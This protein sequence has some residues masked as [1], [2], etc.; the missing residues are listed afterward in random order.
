MPIYKVQG[1]DGHLYSFNGPD[2]ATDDEKIEFASDLYEKR[3]AEIANSPQNKSWLGDLRTAAA[4]SSQNI[5]GGIAHL[6][7]IPSQITRGTTPFTDLATRAGGITGYEPGKRAK[8][9]EQEHSPGYQEGKREQAEAW[10][11]GSA[12]DVM[13]SY[14]RHPGTTAAAIAGALPTMASGIALGGAFGELA[15][16]ASPAIRG[17]IG[18]GAA[19]TGTTAQEL[20]SAPVDERK[21][22]AAATGAGF[23]TGLIGFGGASLARKLGV[24]DPSTLLIGGKSKLNPS[25]ITDFKKAASRGLAMRMGVGA[26]SEGI[27]QELPQSAQEQM[28]QNWAT[29]KD[30]FEGVPQASVEGVLAGS[31]L[32]VATNIPKNREVQQTLA[33]IKE[34]EAA[35][36]QTELNKAAQEEEARVADEQHADL[37]AG[38]GMAQQEMAS[39]DFDRVQAENAAMVPPAPIAPA[40]P[41]PDTITPEPQVTPAL[42]EPQAT[43]A[44]IEPQVTPAP[45]EPQVPVAPPAPAPAPIT[46]PATQPI[47][48]TDKMITDWGVTKGSKEARTLRD[49]IAAVG[50]VATVEQVEQIKS[51]LDNH[52]QSKHRTPKQIELGTAGLTQLDT[53]QS[54]LQLQGAI[55]EQAEAVTDIEAGGDRGAAIGPRIEP[56]LSLPTQQQI[57]APE[58]VKR[59]ETRG[60]DVY[61]AA[62]VAGDDISGRSKE[63]GPDTL[64]TIPTTEKLIIPDSPRKDKIDRYVDE[65]GGFWN[66]DDQ[67]EGSIDEKPIKPS[68][69]ERA[70]IN[71]KMARR[72]PQLSKKGKGKQPKKIASTIDKIREAVSKLISPRQIASKP[73]VIVDSLHELTGIVPEEILNQVGE[74][75]AFTHGNQ[76]YYVANR[77]PEG[78]EVGTVL[79]EKGG[80]MGLTALIG[81]A[82]VKA[83]AN[84]I[85][86]WATP[87]S[88]LTSTTAKNKPENQIA[89]EAK[90]KA[91][92]SGEKPGSARYDQELIAYFT[93]I[94]VNKY[95]I[96]PFKKQPEKYKVVIGWLQDLWAGVTYTLHKLHYN[97]NALTADDVVQLVLGA[98]QVD[99]TINPKTEAQAKAAPVPPQASFAPKP[100]PTQKDKADAQAEGIKLY[101]APAEKNLIGR[102]KQSVKDRTDNDPWGW[103]R[104]MLASDAPHAYKA[105]TMFG[106][107][108][109]LNPATGKEHGMYA[110][111]RAT[112]SDTF[113]KEAGRH[114]YLEL[115]KEGVPHVRDSKDNLY[116]LGKVA[117]E[118]KAAMKA[119]G[120]SDV[121]ADTSFAYM[122]L[123]DRYHELQANGIIDPSE[124]SQKEYLYGKKM[125]AKY[126][127]GFNAW[128]D[129][130]NAIREKTLKFL[131]DTGTFT[132]EKAKQFLDNM[133]YVPFN[134]EQGAQETN[135]QFMGNILSGKRERH[136]KGS[137]R[138]IKDVMENVIDNQLWL[139]KRG[140]NN[141]TANLIADSMAEM[142]KQN[143]LMGGHEVKSKNRKDKDG[144]IIS[145]MKDGKEQFFKVHNKNDAAIFTAPPIWAGITIDILKAA[146][147]LLRKGITLTPRFQY[148]Q[149]IQDPMRAPI[150]AGTKKGI[151]GL[152]K[153]SIPETIKNLRG[154]TPSAKELRRTG[155]AGQIDIHDTTKNWNRTLRGEKRTGV[156]KWLNKAEEI[157]QT[158]DLGLRSAIYKDAIDSGKS[159]NEASLRALM[160]FNPQKR[161]Q[162]AFVNFLIDTIPFMSS[163][164]Q[165]DYKL[166]MALQG[167]IPGVTK[168]DAKQMVMWRVAK[169]AGFATLYA[170]AMSGDDEYENADEGV[171]N[172]NF[173]F[174]G[175]IRIP[176]PPEL[177]LVK[178]AAEKSYRL[179]TE[180]EN[181]TASKA[182]RAGLSEA[183]GLVI[184]ASDLST[185]LMKPMLEN[186]T[187]HSLFTG[188]P[189][190][191]ESLQGRDV[192]LQ[193][194]E[195]TSSM[196]KAIS[197]ALYEA[198]ESVGTGGNV[199]NMSPIKIDNLIKGLTGSIGQEVLNVTDMIVGDKPETELHKMPVIGGA[200]YDTT[201]TARVSDF[202]DILDKATKAHNTITELEKHDPDRVEKYAEKNQGLLGVYEDANSIAKELAELR[203]AKRM[204]VK[205]NPKTARKE[206]QEIDAQATEMLNNALPYLREAIGD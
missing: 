84:R 90:E 118:I 149:M 206:I 51:L 119:D 23:L 191:G 40:P 137:E 138:T 95:K 152:M 50:P 139:M 194:R 47:I 60:V 193:Y 192:N 94:A 49:N 197:N 105:V 129:R 202:Y 13:R 24:T 85:T 122:M 201:G 108:Q 171:K 14:F 128:R 41:I 126:N 196:S 36:V 96:D 82:R 17:A 163:R 142:N 88:A 57:T 101:H 100:Q 19:T 153:T 43:P 155:V 130:H 31:P 20:E 54:Q 99:A 205:E 186:M 148:S 39:Q 46:P 151:L 76:D 200:F 91:D 81:N 21:K 80:H 35:A 45:I 144:T 38:V 145:Y 182:I 172:H 199:I 135:K 103:F 160:H 104:S 3:Q 120:M 26:A 9:L 184:S 115:D 59:D 111:E 15:G 154:E 4:I 178:T 116:E 61:G 134:R 67:L 71:E 164:I 109:R 124:F 110:F 6:L 185:S 177:Q 113:A 69:V 150:T 131:V 195:G 169:F 98:A 1:P 143:P 33:D 66:A 114:G 198:G 183:A 156:S 48:I 75:K 73:P 58:E 55:N 127:K 93:E 70:Y 146:K 190:V 5:P 166:A 112:H 74:A 10:K 52:L 168:K 123:A 37:M 203:E 78:E 159:Q 92:A 68:A 44:L 18:E 28:F 125:Q 140:L 147:S 53:V 63:T 162:S 87:P 180:Q 102:I 189:L 176:V 158:Q 8:E 161:G 97:P 157:A 204:A 62:A 2:D 79:H 29:G 86:R 89:R 30:I 56:S 64:E 22:G 77:I 174:P 121:M 7:D 16:I 188:K 65:E 187:N 136:I 167:R 117:D 179:A 72:D 181:E 12:A 106:P 132:P 11:T 175:G 25:D 173:L 133:E 170:M 83:L 34:K 141:N 27:I 42:I 32:G 165:G 107:E